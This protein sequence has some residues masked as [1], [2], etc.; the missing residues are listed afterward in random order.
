[1]S[2]DHL[3]TFARGLDVIRVFTHHKP[4]LTLSEV[5]AETGLTRATARRFLLT[6]VKEGYV[7]VEGRYFSLLPKV[8]D[9]G[10]SVFVSMDIWDVAKPIIDE[11]AEELQESVNAAILDNDAV[12]YLARAQPNRMVSVGIR[13]GHRMPAYAGST[14][15]ILLAALSEEDLR[16]YLENTTLTAITPATITSKVRL[17]DEI[18]QARK[19]GYAYVE[20]ELEIGLRSIS[21]PI[22][23]LDNDVVAALN[24]GCPSGRVDEDTMRGPMLTALREAS[25]RITDSLRG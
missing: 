2:Q 11:L 14:G 10:F 23:N 18:E 15:R 13:V 22:R 4:R 8:F 24:I 3:S 21:V 17:R 1:M 25:Q 19:Q 6:L 16:E 5:A 9:L 7:G 12:I 20:D